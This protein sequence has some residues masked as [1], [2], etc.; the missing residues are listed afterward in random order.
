MNALEKITPQAEGIMS[1]IARAAAD[2]T[3]NVEKMER[4][5]AMLS[6]ENARIASQQ[7][8]QAMSLAQTEMPHIVK[9]G[10]NPSTNSRYALL[11]TLSKKALPIYTKHGFSLQFSQGECPSP[12]K[13]RVVCK[14]SHVGGH[15]ENYF[16]DLSPDDTGAKGSPSKTKIHGE[17]STFAYGRRY[18]TTMIFNMTIV[19]EDDDGNQGCAVKPEGPST[20]APAELS[21]KDLA[22][23]LWTV[24]TPIRG[25][26]QNW[27][28]ANQWLWREDILDGGIPE[29]A[30]H[31]SA[32]RF[33]EVIQ[34]STDKLKGAK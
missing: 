26:E 1:V 15:S 3:V 6:Q 17:G 19:N 20:V 5:Y 2:P 25:A 10:R 33:E 28:A 9:D 30:P 4:L 14:V 29:T 13:I 23:K 34:K 18:L 21:L 27:N 16:L 12:P 11:E 31:L 7:F 24:L 22:R 32:K 8:N